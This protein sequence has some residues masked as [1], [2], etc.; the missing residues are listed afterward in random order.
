[1]SRRLH[2]R[3][4]PLLVS[5][6][7]V[8]AMVVAAPLEA[9]DLVLV[10]ANVVDVRDGTV[11][12]DATVVVR[13]GR[14]VSVGGTAPRDGSV[15]TVDLQGMYLMPGLIDAH[16]HISTFDQARR[17]LDSGVTTVR[18]MGADNYTDV[19]LGA[20]AAAGTIESP[21]VV[22]AGYHVR[23]S[24][25]EDFFKNHPDLGHYRAGGIVGT[26][27]VRAMARAL[28]SRDIDFIKVNATERA[29]LPD[30]DPRK[31]LYGVEEMRVLVEEARAA[32]IQG[33]AAHAHGDEGGRA[34]VDAGVRSIE[35]GTYLSPETLARMA[36]QGTFL[37][38]TVAIVRDLTIPGGDYESPVLQMRGRHMLPRVQETVG[39]AH[40]AGV[41]IVA[42]T[43][44]GYGPNSVV[45]LSHEVEELVTIGL[46]A[47]EAL[48]AAT[49]TAAELLGVADRTGHIAEGMEADLI[50]T[51]RNP[52][53]DVRALQD[54][55][56][57]VNDGRVA[58]TKGDWFAAARASS[59]W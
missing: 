30:T 18:S 25:A 38:P 31:Q 13:D 23:P 53:E 26:E 45:R 59:S 11:R 40:R 32:G 36:E 2:L 51:E 41:R 42:A 39:H 10:R 58:M 19:G 20:L 50:V 12:R 35:H 48:Q 24:P 34:A 49:V 37:V 43:D 22:A 46:S 27:A 7:A 17:A 4:T 29:G 57:V 8:A 14:I 21:E 55:L 54:V 52:L 5:L 47:R 15:R 6:A 28:V 9:Q 44:T 16:V 33:V 56:L 3:R 1:M